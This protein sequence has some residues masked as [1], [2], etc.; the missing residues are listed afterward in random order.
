M[1]GEEKVGYE[2]SKKSTYDFSRKISGRRAHLG[3][4]SIDGRII[5]KWILKRKSVRA[6]CV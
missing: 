4:L 3:D 2:L 6:G 1:K 5:L